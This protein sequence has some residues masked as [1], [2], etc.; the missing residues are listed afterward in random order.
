MRGK[1]VWFRGVRSSF[2]DE[3]NP[4]LVMWGGIN[5]H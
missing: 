2:R 3:A 4:N 1:V 5:T